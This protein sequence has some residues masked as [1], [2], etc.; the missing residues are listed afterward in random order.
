MKYVT[1]LASI[2][3]LTGC[4][5]ETVVQEGPDAE[6]THDGLHRIDHAAFEYAYVDPDADWGRYVGILPGGAD[7]EFRAVKKTSGT[8]RT[9]SSASEFYMDDDTR[10]KF[11]DEVSAVFAEELA[12]SERF[13][14]T[15]SAGPDVLLIRGGLTD[16][17]SQVPP[18]YVGRSEVFLS[19]VG[20]ATLV[21]EIVDSMSGEVLFRAADRRAAERAGGTRPMLSTPATNWAEVRRLARTWG[22]SLRE[23]LDSLPTS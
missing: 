6:V 8:H 4:A 5:S 22:S 1:I 19:S 7:F 9:S 18:E 10:T 2:M 13:T 14:V 23:G 17:V 15:E 16:I 21:L 3:L 20:E 12:K 11:K